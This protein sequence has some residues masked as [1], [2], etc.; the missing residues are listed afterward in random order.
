MQNLFN[1]FEEQELSLRD[2]MLDYTTAGQWK[3]KLKYMVP[4]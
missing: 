1:T 4:Y 3:N 2:S